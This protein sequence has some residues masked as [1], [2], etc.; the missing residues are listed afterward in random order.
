MAYFEQTKL[1][2]TS[3]VA[4]DPATETTLAALNAKLPAI[5]NGLVP[6]ATQNITTKFR[7]AFETY[8][9]D[10]KWTEVKASGDI[11]SVDGNAASASYLVV[12]KNPL[13]AGNESS[14]SSIASFKLPIELAVGLSIS[15][16]TLGQ[17]FS[18]ELVDTDT[19][20]P[21]V[22]DLAISSITQATTTLTVDTVTPHGLSV[23]KSIGIFGCSNPLANYPALVVQSVPTP[24]Q[25]L[26]TA[27][28]AGAI[29]SLTITNPAG[30]KGS[31]FFRE[32]FGRAQNG[33]SQI[34]EQPTATQSSLYVR[35]ES[36][37][38]FPS[39]TVAGSHSVTVG[40]SAPVALVSAAYQYAFAP[41]TEY[42]MFA[43]ADRTQWAD[44]TV[45]VLTQTTSRLLR[46]QICPDP[47]AEY[48][49]RIRAVN[50]KSL[51]VPNAQI[52]SAVKT[53]TTTATIT[54]DVA[55]GLI[56]NDPVIVYGISN[57]GASSFPNIV[58]AT[59]ITVL[60]ATQFTIT[61]GTAS[62]VT[63]YGGFVAKVQGGNL[64]SALGYNA[65]V[66]QNVT[67]S[68]LSDGTRQLV[69]VGSGSWS[70]LAIGD[71]VNLVGVRNIVN[72]ASLDIDG[73]WK[74]ANVVTN[75]LTLIPMSGT[76]PPANFGL[77]SC[78]GAVIK[79]TE[80]R[81]SFIRLFDY[82][83]QRVEMLPRPSGDLAAS[84]PVV[85]QGGTTAV[86]GSL[87]TVTTVTTVG[88]VTSANLAIPN[89]I[90]DVASAALTTTTTV[91]AITPSAGISYSVV[92]PVT[93]VTGTLPT[94]D[95][96]I[97]ESDDAGTNWYKV[98]DFPRITAVGI[99]R[100]PVISLTGNRVRYVQTVGG[101]TPSFTRAVNR[102]QSNYPSLP[103]RQ[104]IDRSLVLTTLNS[105]TPVLNTQDCGNRA[106]LIVNVG[107]ITTTAPALQIEGSD[108]GGITW[109]SIGAPLTAVASSTVQL[110]EKD[111]NAAQ[112]RVRVST[113]G[114]GVTAGS[115]TLKSHD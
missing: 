14:V 43:Q 90:A 53:G 55:H 114:V 22:A 38:A 67:L 56:T 68:T 95:V 66:L 77:V 31:V 10:D 101:T 63:S 29:P 70:G 96:S 88:T 13:V 23:G 8:T 92:I 9:P 27:G 84:V 105:T 69:I 24:T 99:Y 34:F 112:M 71:G 1:A 85:L 12:S 80:L 100:S 87:T 86:S 16:R 75:N 42:R 30:A 6:V 62:T 74:V 94:L 41:T 91:A 28:P 46:T 59:A 18:V 36:G 32:R 11:I 61:I 49:L 78:G 106:Q 40:T 35:S 64:G 4:V 51:T 45:D 83:R 57:Q 98:Y 81:L 107:A 113:A 47:S 110:T 52:V 39:G 102:L 109:Y 104:L 89:N 58:T 72:G 108:D 115:V 73:A 21:D 15:Q 82:E 3:G 7:E 76:T 25:F 54:T 20:L 44:S 111:I 37:D 97:E 26:C 79:R 48:K 93:V 50:N 103:T 65:V 60:N 2:N 19:P 5:Q 17:E 33:I